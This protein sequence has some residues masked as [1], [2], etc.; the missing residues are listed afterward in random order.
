[1]NP[2]VAMQNHRHLAVSA[3][4]ALAL[5]AARAAGAGPVCFE[6]ESASVV[7]APVEV[8]HEPAA[9][10]DQPRE[11]SGAS[12]QA[13]LEVKQGSGNPPAVTTGVARCEF[14]LPE[15]GTYLMWTRAAWHD[16]CGNSVTIQIDDGT[17][18]T[19]GQDAT[20]KAWHWVK[21]PPRLPQLTLKSGAH[22]L[23]IENRE[24]GIKIDQV[25]FTTDRR[26]VPVGIETSSPVAGNR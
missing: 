12:Q 4:A 20:Y 22:V 9:S 1:M 7:A 23:R 13:Y 15:D 3:L 5:L 25:L 19:V 26:Y 16:E 21:S 24:D 2:V 8:S 14:T 6:A 18:F 10:A 17:P 11:E